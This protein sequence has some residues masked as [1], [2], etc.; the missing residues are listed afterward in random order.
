[1]NRRDFAWTLT[2]SALTAAS[3]Q[4]V[5]GA[6]DRLGMALIGSGRRGREVMKAFLDTDAAELHCLCD[7]Y[8][9][10]RDRARAMLAS[11]TKP[12]ECA[13]HQDALA[14]R[15]VDAVLI[16]V[17]DHWHLDIALDSFKA[18]KHVYLEKPATHH[19]SEGP[20]LLRGA[21][22]SGKICQIGT[23]QRS[24]AHYIR[25]KEE[26]FGK[27]K[28]GDVVLVRTWW[29]NF[30]WQA[31]NIPKTPKPPGLDWDRFLGRTPYHEYEHARY[32]S[33]RYFPDYGG[34]VLADILNHWA[35]VAQW[36]MDAH[37]PRTAVATGGIYKLNDGRVNPDVVNAIVQYDG[38][39]LSFESTVL[40]VPDERP[41]L[42]F[43][44]TEG[45]LD[46]ARSSY[47]FR[48]NKGEPRTVAASGSLEI[49]HARDFVAAIRTG[50]KPNADVDIALEGVLPCHL[51]RAA[52][53]NGKRARYDAGRNTIL[54]D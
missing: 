25:A 13:H 2:S 45:S 39:N 9:A 15:D 20:A 48:P 26:I 28:L 38:W 44:G 36:M 6:N 12:Y 53:W 40:P 34:G 1:M 11:A 8:D 27:R 32:D 49:A 31:R 51:A 19:L 42:L 54:S 21:R 14:R 18:G 37:A 17:P 4:R 52:Y 3:Y 10:Q 35:D 23:Q 46:L 33:W 5:M 50:K 47:I 29:S 7:I 16:G 22:L 30:P 43:L 41:G 24:G